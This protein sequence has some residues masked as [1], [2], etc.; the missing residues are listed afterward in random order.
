MLAM[1]TYHVRYCWEVQRARVGEG[2]AAVSLG[3]NPATAQVKLSWGQCSTG[4]SP[5]LSSTVRLAC[6][7]LTPTALESSPI[8]GFSMHT[9]VAKLPLGSPHE[10]TRQ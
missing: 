7:A 5:R 3:V 8:Y 9:P 1:L 2:A 4:H 10:D 6:P